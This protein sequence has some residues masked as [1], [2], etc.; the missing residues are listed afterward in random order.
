MLTTIKRAIPTPLK[1]TLRR[2]FYNAYSLVP[3]VRSEFEP[4][5]WMDFVGNTAPGQFGP[6]GRELLQQARNF[7]G[8]QQFHDVLD[9][10]CGVGHFAA[11]LVPFLEPQARYEG[12]DIVPSGI[13]WCRKAITAKHPQFHFQVADIY[14]SYYNPD[15]RF[16]GQDYRF[17]YDDA[18]FDFIVLISVFTHMMK[19]EIDHYLSEIRRVLRPEGRVLLTA[20]LL[21]ADARA[22]IERG[23]TTGANPLARRFGFSL[24][25]GARVDDIEKPEAAIAHDVDWFIAA[26]QQHSLRVT[27]RPGNWCRENDSHHVHDFVI[28]S[29]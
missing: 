10:G 15:G 9:I 5:F 11:A 16:R 13:A 22:A 3:G 28:L 25:D 19:P 27:M 21:S 20:F 7:A 29:K 17:P 1:A 14:N 4:P 24:P 12:F 23:H 26:C 8:L 18:S 2:S 6:V